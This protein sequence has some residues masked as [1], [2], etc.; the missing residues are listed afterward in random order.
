M[1]RLYAGD[2][3]ALSS[4]EMTE[5]RDVGPSERATVSAAPV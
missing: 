1:A 5:R 4:G 2:G 3:N